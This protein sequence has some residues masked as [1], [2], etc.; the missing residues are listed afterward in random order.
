MK[1]TEQQLYFLDKLFRCIKG[2]KVNFNTDVTFVATDMFM[3]MCDYFGCNS[4]D[5]VKKGVYVF[6]NVLTQKSLFDFYLPNATFHCYETD[7]KLYFFD[8]ENIQE[9][10]ETN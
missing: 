4:A 1:R 9:V 3:S 2:G 6:Q 7:Q 8:L 5:N 10:E